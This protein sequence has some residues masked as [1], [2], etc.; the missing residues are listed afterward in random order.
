MG[1]GSG[2]DSSPGRSAPPSSDQ[3][4]RER[5]KDKL[6]GSKLS[7][8][9]ILA[10]LPALALAATVTPLP[11]QDAPPV[12]APADNLTIDGVPPLPARLSGDVRRYTESRS[13]GLADWH[14]TS[15]EM[16]IVTRFGNT[17]Q[18]HGVKTP[19]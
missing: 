16:L 13:A 18:L 8:P 3:A 12:I 11:A 1:G 9:A 19:G 15:R 10:A 6:V 4:L 17:V 5:E 2:P 14:P 7:R